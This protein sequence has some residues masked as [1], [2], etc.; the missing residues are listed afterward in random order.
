MTDKGFRVTVEDLETGETGT[1][2]VGAGDYILVPF[3]PCY[4]DSVVRHKN[5]TIQFT[6]KGHAPK[7][8]STDG[9]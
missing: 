8:V 5:G 3:E 2:V 9:Q 6:L 4:L 7:A 1:R